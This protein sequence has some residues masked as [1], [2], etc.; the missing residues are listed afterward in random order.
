MFN[1]KKFFIYIFETNIKF[2]YIYIYVERKFINNV[3]FDNIFIQHIH[4]NLKINKV[5][6]YNIL[7]FIHRI[8]LFKF[9]DKIL[10]YP[11]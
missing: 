6:L 2:I 11:L 4:I 9:N 1:V 5:Y 7:I 8:C 10:A 3:V